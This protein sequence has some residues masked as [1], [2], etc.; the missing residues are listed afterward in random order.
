MGTKITSDPAMKSNLCKAFSGQ[1]IKYTTVKRSTQ[2]IAD[3]TVAVFACCQPTSFLD[4][5]SK[6]KD[7]QGLYDRFLDFVIRV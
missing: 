7:S 1:P 4:I 6:D 3:H 2:V 5:L